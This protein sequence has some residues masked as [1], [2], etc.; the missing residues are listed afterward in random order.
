MQDPV[1]SYTPTLMRFDLRYPLVR[2]TK[3]L[4]SHLQNLWNQISLLVRYRSAGVTEVIS[5]WHRHL[6]VSP[7]LLHNN[8]QGGT[9]RLLG[10]DFDLT[11]TNVWEFSPDTGRHWPKQFYKRYSLGLGRVG[12]YKLVWELGRL[13]FL[14]GLLAHDSQ[15]GLRVLHSYLAHDRPLRTIHWY[16][17]MEIGIRMISLMF[18]V[19]LLEAYEDERIAT[20]R[21][22]DLQYRFLRDH[23]TSWWPVTNNH[24][25]VELSALLAYEMLFAGPHPR[26][27]AHWEM[28]ERA[29]ERQIYPDGGIREQS[30][31][32]TRFNLDAYLLLWILCELTSD[33]VPEFLKNAVERM[34]EFVIALQQP[35]G[36]LPQIG[37][38][39]GGRVIP[40][41]CYRDYWD[42][43]G[44]LAVGAVL[45]NRPDFKWAAGSFDN[46]FTYMLPDSFA[47]RFEGLPCK[48][49]EPG[50]HCFADS[51]YWV[52]RSSNE[53]NADYLVMRAGEFG[54][55]GAGYAPHSHCDELSVILCMSGLPILVD[56]G[57]YTYDQFNDGWRNHFR[58]NA[59]HNILEV[60]GQ[61]QAEFRPG[62]NFSWG[63]VPRAHFDTIC[64][65][66]ARATLEDWAGHYVWQREVEVQKGHIRL[67]DH[68][69]LAD[70]GNHVVKWFF[71]FHPDVRTI[72]SDGRVLL[73]AGDKLLYLV[74]DNLPAETQLSLV[75]G[76][77]SERYNQRQE[78]TRLEAT[79]RIQETCEVR[80]TITSES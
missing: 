63:R 46:D 14:P 35:F 41:A 15:S 28:L 75:K 39:D 52:W 70:A 68:V 48:P 49:P 59:C 20:L 2:G 29:T 8:V 44:H 26:H 21:L 65:N 57:T 78:H 74:A 7:S 56:C 53:P 55:G 25:L 9:V 11:Q 80:W 24:L 38:A 73:Q 34:L 23:L 17:E 13:Q 72:I 16:S 60:D 76:Y 45:C 62:R 5:V 64:E 6:Q 79:A 36:T 30:T 71:N 42:F 40:T 3:Q 1:T 12:D 31:S 51:G 22:V 67:H 4:Q 50:S 43:R 27:Q 10:H 18:C 37:D 69:S 61:P 77:Y 58:G 66:R 32:Y 33:P 54:L 47:D 19:P